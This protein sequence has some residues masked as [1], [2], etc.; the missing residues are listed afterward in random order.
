MIMS[1]IDNN[2]IIGQESGVLDLKIEL[3]KKFECNDCKSMVK[4]V[5]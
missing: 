4:Y 1:W 3:K 2:A 5:G